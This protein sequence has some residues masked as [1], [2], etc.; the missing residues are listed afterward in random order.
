MKSRGTTCSFWLLTSQL[1]VLSIPQQK[2]LSKRLPLCSSTFHIAYQQL[3]PYTQT[4]HNKTRGILF[5][6][7]KTAIEACCN[8]IDEHPIRY[9]LTTTDF[10]HLVEDD[11]LHENTA[12]ILPIQR[13]GSADHYIGH[14]YVPTIQSPGFALF[15]RP[16][17]NSM[18]LMMR[19][20]RPVFPLLVIAVFGCHYRRCPVLVHREHL[21][22]VRGGIP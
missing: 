15:V 7:F 1:L 22:C 14:P 13:S 3:P 11:T 16:L 5:D 2:V 19:A 4:V 12:F 8:R 18:A 21:P 10:D 20:I 9:I 6:T 17:P